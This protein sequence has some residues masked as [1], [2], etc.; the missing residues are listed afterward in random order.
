VVCRAGATTLAELTVCK[1]PSILIPFPAAADNHQVLNAQSLVDAGAALM[2]EERDLTGSCCAG[3][4]RAA[5]GRAAPRAHGAG[6]RHEW[7]TPGLER[8]RQRLR[9]PG[10]AALGVAPGPGPRAGLPPH[11]A[12]HRRGRPGGRRVPMSLFRSLQPHIHF[13]GIGGIGMSGIAELLVNLGYPVSGSEPQGVGDHPPPGHPGRPH[14][15]RHDAAHVADAD[16]VVTSSASGAT[17]RRWPPPGPERFR[18]SPGR[19]AGRADAPQGG[20]RH[21]R[22]PRQDHHHLPGR[23]PAGPRRARPDPRWWAAR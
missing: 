3:D 10:A 20:H 19:D 14:P 8:D 9:R 22:L 23:P 13:V 6:R 7:A 21:R 15:P 12:R 17:T 1:K 5:G 2:I 16:V 11:P 18:S 4:P